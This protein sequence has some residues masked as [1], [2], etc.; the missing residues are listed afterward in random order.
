[1]LS[2]DG[3]VEAAEIKMKNDNKDSYR[4]GSHSLSSQPWLCQ[5]FKVRQ[6]NSK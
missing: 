2:L 4:A 3:G 5:L 1:M 6:V